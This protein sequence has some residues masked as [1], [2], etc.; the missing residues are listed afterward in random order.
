M[1]SKCDSEELSA[2]EYIDNLCISMGL[3]DE[4]GGHLKAQYGRNRKMYK[5]KMNKECFSPLEVHSLLRVDRVRQDE[6]SFPVYP[7]GQKTSLRNGE[8]HS[9]KPPS[10]WVS[11]EFELHYPLPEQK[12]FS[13]LCAAARLLNLPERHLY[14]VRLKHKRGGVS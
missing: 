2:S 9:Q 14:Q 3:T 4:T 10:D 13:S 11:A 6:I 5:S 12:E 7:T 8:K 1:P